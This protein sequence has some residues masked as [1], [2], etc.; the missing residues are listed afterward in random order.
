MI[1]TL[2]GI[3]VSL[4]SELVTWLNKKLTG[5]VIQ[6]DAAFII[7][8]VLSIV[9]AVVK[10]VVLPLLPSSYMVS[11][12]LLFAEVFAS[13]QIFFKLFSSK[14]GLVVSDPTTV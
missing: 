8:L 11:M 14:V 12:G 7:V 9:V 5:T 13:S 3:G 6:G 1:G 2:L 4:F 10:T